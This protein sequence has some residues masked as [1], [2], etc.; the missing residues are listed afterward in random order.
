MSNKNRIPNTYIRIREKQAKT[1][2]S[3][4]QSK[5]LC[6]IINDSFK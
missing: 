5:V 3:Y 2:L 1:I 4:I 6:K